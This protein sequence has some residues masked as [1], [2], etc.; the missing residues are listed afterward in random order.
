[1]TTT[2][3]RSRNG[4]LDKADRDAFDDFLARIS[5]GAPKILIHMHGGLVDQKTAEGI[6]ARLSGKGDT[7]YNAPEDWE[8][9]FIVWRTGALE[10]LRTNWRD[11]ATND[12]LYRT[13]LRRLLELLSDKLGFKGPDGRSLGTNRLTR[14]EI[15]AEL[16]EDAT[17][18][19]QFFDEQ[20]PVAVAGRS[21]I[22][23]DAFEADLEAE[24]AADEE[25]EEVAAEIE[26]G[27]AAAQPRAVGSI[28]ADRSPHLARRLLLSVLVA[29]RRGRS[30]PA[31]Y[32]HPAAPIWC[33]TRGTRNGRAVHDLLGRAPQPAQPVECVGPA[34]RLR[35]RTRSL[36][37]LVAQTVVECFVHLVDALAL[38]ADGQLLRV[39]RRHPYMPAQRF[40]GSAVDACFEHFRR[41]VLARVGLDDVRRRRLAGF[42]HLFG[43]RNRL[44]GHRGSAGHG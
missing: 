17:E 34:C 16:T 26:A 5:T 10:T 42:Q 40:Q 20:N 38:L 29:A 44:D 13:L 28:R 36:V 30:R 39:A 18:P 22:N 19:F 23:P 21:A 6:A 35:S 1:M 33:R 15:E 37:G 11:L 7:A 32:R 24:L 31:Q 43:P 8:Q 25:L 2:V 9:L 41:R 4:I 12:R 3:L 27:I 14:A